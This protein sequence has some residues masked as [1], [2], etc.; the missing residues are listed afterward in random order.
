[1]TVRLTS[2]LSIS[3]TAALCLFLAACS[4]TEPTTPSEAKPTVRLFNGMA[5]SKQARLMIAATAYSPMVSSGYQGPRQELSSAMETVDVVVDNGTTSVVHARVKGAFPAS[6]NSSVVVF[7]STSMFEPTRLSDTVVIVR[8][9]GTVPSGKCRLR[10]INATDAIGELSVYLGDERVVSQSELPFRSMSRWITVEPGSHLMRVVR[11]WQIPYD[12]AVK[13]VALVAGTSYTLFLS[14]T[15]QLADSWPFT[16]RLLSENSLEAP[17]DLLIPPDV[18]NFQIVNA[19]IGVRSFDVK[20]DGKT[21]PKMMQVAFPNATG[22]QELDLGTHTLEVLANGTPLVTNVRTL[23]TLRSR[24]TMFVTGTLVPPNIVGM[25]LEE[26]ER[27]QDPTM[28]SLRVVNLSP[29]APLLDIALQQDTTELLPVGFRSLEFRESSAVAGTTNQFITIAPGQYRLVAY[30]AGS[31]N[32]V[33]PPTEVTLEAGQV[34]TLWVG[35]LLSSIGLYS[36]NH[37][38]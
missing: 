6:S 25:E 32:V 21:S 11:Q 38:K 26:P 23:A 24:K 18:G 16:P 35:G 28:T 8:D 12:A 4:S 2:S 3:V 17:I 20:I 19:V 14:G 10:V 27:A 29:D 34:R 1:M 7:P 22:Y 33:L 15:L 5:P 37:S 13:E 30:R 9:S 36:V 31:K